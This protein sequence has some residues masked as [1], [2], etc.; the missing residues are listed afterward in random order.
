MEIITSADSM[1]EELPSMARKKFNNDPEQFLEY[2]QNPDNIT[3][4][5][6]MG[7]LDPRYNPDIATEQ[8]NESEQ[9]KGSDATSNS[10]GGSDAT[11][12]E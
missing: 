8:S 6:E 7:L 9:S 12:S 2:V 1:F 11:A 5:H 4:L 10:E 3:S